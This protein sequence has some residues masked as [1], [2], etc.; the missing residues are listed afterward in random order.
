MIEG[1]LVLHSQ[2]MGLI[3]QK[4]DTGL[5]MQDIGITSIL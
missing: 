1:F 5:G 3:L 2:T 4:V